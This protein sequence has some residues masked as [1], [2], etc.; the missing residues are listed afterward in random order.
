MSS[1]TCKTWFQ[2]RNVQVSYFQFSVSIVLCMT[3]PNSG[4]RRHST[5]S[6]RSWQNRLRLQLVSVTRKKWGSELRNVY[7]DD[8]R[9]GIIACCTAAYL[10]HNCKAAPASLTW[11]ANPWSV[12]HLKF[13]VR[14]CLFLL[15]DGATLFVLDISNSQRACFIKDMP[16]FF[17]RWLI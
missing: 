11:T 5:R 13:L 14:V 12:I 8:G 3:G 15:H 16:Y 6:V 2:S 9:F 17:I 10:T 4:A 7:H 1:N